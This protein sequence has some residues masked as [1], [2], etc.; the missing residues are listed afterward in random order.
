MFW[1]DRLVL[2]ALDRWS[3]WE[4]VL[5]TAIV[6]FEG[7]PPGYTVPWSVAV[8]AAVASVITRGGS[9]Y[10]ALLLVI[11]YAQ[12]AMDCLGNVGPVG[13]CHTR[14]INS[15]LQIDYIW[16]APKQ[17]FWYLFFN[18]IGSTCHHLFS[19]PQF[20]NAFL[21]IRFLTNHTKLQVDSEKRSIWIDLICEHFSAIRA[22]IERIK[23]LEREK[24]YQREKH[25]NTFQFFLK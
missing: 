17:V 12:T 22:L 15:S 9:R 25:V 8:G 23:I 5:A 10:F 21:V 4:N 1:V 7:T 14:W 11:D 6:F 2:V 18:A 16:F 19:L 3:W 24:L 13:R 20:T